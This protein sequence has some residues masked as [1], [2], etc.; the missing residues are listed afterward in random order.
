[1]VLHLADQSLNSLS[2]PDLHATTQRTQMAAAIKSWITSL[3][4]GEKFYSGL[5]WILFQPLNHLS[6]VSCAALRTR[7][8]SARLVAET[9]VFRSRDHDAPSTRILTPLFHAVTAM[10]SSRILRFCPP[11]ADRYRARIAFASSARDWCVILVSIVLRADE[12][13]MVA[14]AVTG[15]TSREATTQRGNIFHEAMRGQGLASA[16]SD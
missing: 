10:N 8:T 15:K 9:T 7:A 2:A 4:F 16:A 1:M 13:S 12:G 11:V 5:I 14:R 3:E 6:P